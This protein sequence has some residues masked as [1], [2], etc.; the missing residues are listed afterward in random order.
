MYLF[1]ELSIFLG[2]LFAR[3]QRRKAEKAEAAARS[4][5]AAQ[6]QPSADA[7]ES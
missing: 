3:T 5:A 7:D 6:E 1:Y 4:G 2:W